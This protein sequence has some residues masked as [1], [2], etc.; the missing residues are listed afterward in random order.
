M[1]FENNKSVDNKMNRILNYEFFSLYLYCFNDDRSL[2]APIKDVY[3]VW[4]GSVFR[5][6]KPKIYLYIFVYVYVNIKKTIKTWIIKYNKLSYN[7]KTINNLKIWLIL[8][9]IF[10]GFNNFSL[11]PFLVH[12][13]SA[14]QLRPSLMLAQIQNSNSP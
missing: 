3:C 11:S 8:I 6:A 14:I 4:A 10:I 13:I 7:Y 1:I 12:S 9:T 2:A 5:W